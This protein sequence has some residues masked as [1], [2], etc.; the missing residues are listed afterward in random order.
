MRRL[1]SNPPDSGRARQ[2]Q[3]RRGDAGLHVSDR[4]TVA[5]IQPDARDVKAGD[6]AFVIVAEMPAGRKFEDLP[7]KFFEEMLYDPPESTAAMA[8][9]KTGRWSRTLA[10]VKNPNGAQQATETRPEIRA[11]DLQRQH[12]GAQPRLGDRGGRKRLPARGGS[13]ATR[14]KKVEPDLL[15]IQDSF[16]VFGRR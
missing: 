12:G 15:A 2:R 16:R 1:Y 7:D 6:S 13:F 14:Y 4:L 5:G 3:R 9:S 8:P 10:Q 11:A